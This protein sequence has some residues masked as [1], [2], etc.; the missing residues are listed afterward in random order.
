MANTV[1]ISELR[2]YESVLKVLDSVATDEPVFLSGGK[3][4]YAIVDMKEYKRMKASI[5]LMNELEKGRRSGETNGWH[6]PE[7]V[8]E[9]LRKIKNEVH[10]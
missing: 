3:M 6:S 4:G 2:D 10:S 7:D 5:W 8:A 9:Y 1:P